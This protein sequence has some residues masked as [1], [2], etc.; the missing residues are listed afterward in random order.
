MSY[1]MTT[2][3]VLVGSQ[4]CKD[5]IPNKGV[6]GA[7]NTSWIPAT[8]QNFGTQTY[9][10]NTGGSKTTT[11]ELPE[12]SVGQLVKWVVSGSVR[13][14]VKLPLGQAST[15]HT[16]NVKLPASGQYLDLESKVVRSGGYTVI[17]KSVTAS[18]LADDVSEPFSGTFPYYR[19]S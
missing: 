15:T 11:L 17:T 9:S 10:T 7:E 8:N 3:G 2:S 12:V 13:A 4:T 16:V 14:V 19:I 5:C 6:I 18:A 1:N